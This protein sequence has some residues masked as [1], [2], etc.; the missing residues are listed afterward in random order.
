MFQQ[1]Y[2]YMQGQQQGQ[3]GQ[4]QQYIQHQQQY[5]QMQQ[6]QMNYQMQHHQHQRQKIDKPIKGTIV[7][8]CLIWLLKKAQLEK[9]CQKATEIKSYLH[10]WC[11]KRGEKPEYTYEANGKPPKVV[12]QNYALLKLHWQNHTFWE[13]AQLWL[14]LLSSKTHLTTLLPK[15]VSK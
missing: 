9:P 5:Q 8:N 2:G 4:Y 3:P 10:A 12:N 1:D 14:L 11:T 6:P 13:R 7:V 15:S